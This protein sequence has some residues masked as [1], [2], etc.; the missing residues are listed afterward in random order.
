[1]YSV[2][3]FSLRAV[4]GETWQLKKLV[5]FVLAAPAEISPSI[6]ALTNS[7]HA[8]APA[9]AAHSRRGYGPQVTCKDVG[10]GREPEHWPQ[11]DDFRLMQLW[12]LMM[13]YKEAAGVQFDNE[14]E[15]QVQDC[16]NIAV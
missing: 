4:Y 6:F 7:L 9:P 2:Y 11:L 3:G 1:M 15:V 10:I 14:I 12:G 16:Q 13:I 8:Q 5:A